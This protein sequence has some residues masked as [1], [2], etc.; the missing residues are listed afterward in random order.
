MT[1]LTYF[2]CESEYDYMISIPDSAL[3]CLHSIE[4]TPLRILPDISQMSQE[5]EVDGVGDGA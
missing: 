2:D 3:A 4:N 1:D 5:V